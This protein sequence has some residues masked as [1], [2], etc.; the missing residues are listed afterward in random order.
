MRVGRYAVAALALLLVLAAGLG[1]VGR[2]RLDGALTQVAAVDVPPDGVLDAAAQTGDEN[3]LVSPSTAAGRPAPRPGRTP[4]PSCTATRGATGPSRSRCPPQLEITRPPCERWD[5]AAA[6]YLGQT[7]PAE[8]RTTFDSAYAVGG[9]RCATRAAQQVTGLAITRF[10]A[11]D[12][13]ATSALVEAVGGVQ[14]CVEQPVLDSVLGPVVA[15]AGTDAFNGARAATLVR[16]ADVRG[17]PAGGAALVQRQQRVL[18]AA[19]ERALSPT[20]LLHPG[21]VGRLLPALGTAVVST[22]TGVADLLALSSAPGE[23]RAVPTEP[24]E[25]SRGNVEMRKTEAQALFTAVRTDAPLPARDEAA[26]TASAPADVTADV[27]NASGRDG[28]AA[29]VAGTL[30]DLGFRTAE[31]RNAGQPALDTVVRFSPDRAEQAQLLAARGAVGERGARSRHH[32]R[33][34]A[35]AGPVVRRHGPRL[36]RSGGSRRRSAPHRPRPAAE[37]R[38][39]FTGGSSAAPAPPERRN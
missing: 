23:V 10:V 4:S 28:L 17:E 32:R 1:W 22:G 5:P 39:P 34:A 7:V 33:A 27:L 31:V 13:A 21:R 12:L 18:A 37:R 15:T 6:A 3:V 2:T 9:P 30:G 29:E 20:A 19:L 38:P 24:Q 36:H 8:P 25:N 11:V 14:V 35:R 16:A 26:A